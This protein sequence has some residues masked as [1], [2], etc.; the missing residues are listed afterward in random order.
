[1]SFTATSFVFM[2]FSIYLTF[3]SVED[4]TVG[5]NVLAQLTSFFSSF[6]LLIHTFGVMAAAQM[7]K[8]EVKRLKSIKQESRVNLIQLQAKK[9]AALVHKM[10]NNE[11][12]EIN[13]RK[14]S[15][16]SQ[17]L[18]HRVPI[19]TCGLFSFDSKL[20]FSVRSFRNIQQT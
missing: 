15:N 8:S 12:D 17:Q 6:C 14:L 5:Y 10:L 1:M 16:F 13:I 3:M 2:I 18:L 4:E 7:V 9:S 19:F 11:D 20:A